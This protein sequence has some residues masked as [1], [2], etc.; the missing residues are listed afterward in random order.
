M[1]HAEK[2]CK[3]SCRFDTKQIKTD[4]FIKKITNFDWYFYG[5]KIFSTCL[6]KQTFFK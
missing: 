5:T 4:R 2:K 3:F 6:F 1:K